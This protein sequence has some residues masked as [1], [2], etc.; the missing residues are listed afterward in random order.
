MNYHVGEWDKRC[1]CVFCF[2]LYTRRKNRYMYANENDP[3]E[4]KQLTDKR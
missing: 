3:T 2:C 4:I 1:V